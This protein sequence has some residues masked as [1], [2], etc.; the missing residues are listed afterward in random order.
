MI[1]Q[2]EKYCNWVIKALLWYFSD[3]FNSDEEA[4][5]NQKRL[6]GSLFQSLFNCLK[7]DTERYLK[8]LIVYIYHNPFHHKFT[9][10]LLDYQWMSYNAILSGNDAFLNQDKELERVGA[11]ENFKYL[12]Q[13]LF[14]R[15]DFNS[16]FLAWL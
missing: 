14:I 7:F 4:I 2:N 10:D 9:F 13:K 8:N 15:S 12:H 16:C 6:T 5:D 3:L 1:K 11:M